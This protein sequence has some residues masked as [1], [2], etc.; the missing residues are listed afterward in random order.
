MGLGVKKGIP[1]KKDKNTKKFFFENFTP[2]DDPMTHEK[3][4]QQK[5]FFVYANTK[6]FSRILNPNFKKN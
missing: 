1:Q 4:Y 2:N 6:K 3:I 5:M